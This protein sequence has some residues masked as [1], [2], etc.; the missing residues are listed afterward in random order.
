MA[1][2]TPDRMVI[3]KLGN[4]EQIIFDKDLLTQKQIRQFRLDIANELEKYLKEIS[5][6]QDSFQDLAKKFSEDT[7][8]KEKESDKAY[9]KRVQELTEKFKEDAAKLRGPDDAYWKQELAGRLLRVIARMALQEAKV[10]PANLDD[11]PWE[12]M[13]RQ[14]AEFLINNECDAGT[15]FLPPR[16]SEEA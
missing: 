4:N 16:L 15:H 13:K 12:P 5:E 3:F 8:R 11:A 10:T 9:E 7:A 6:F 2:T 14:L 1:P